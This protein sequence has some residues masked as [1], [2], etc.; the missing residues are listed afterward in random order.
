MRKEIY[1]QIDKETEVSKDKAELGRCSTEKNTNFK[2]LPSQCESHLPGHIN[3]AVLV[4]F[5]VA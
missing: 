4:Q 5:S 2:D 3:S 1:S